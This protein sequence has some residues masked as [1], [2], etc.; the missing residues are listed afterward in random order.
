[1]SLGL[2]SSV[3]RD[4][5]RVSV[6]L[7]AFALLMLPAIEQESTGVR[8][9]EARA[10]VALV[11]PSLPPESAYPDVVLERDP[12]EAVAA[13]DPAFRTGGPNEAVVRAVIGGTRPLA[14][15]EFGGIV[16]AVSIGDSIGH[17]HVASIGEHGVVLDSGTLLTFADAKS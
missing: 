5:Q 9:A 16:R 12:F 4:L 13:F 3:R 8:A 17:E 1:V 6:A 7:C 2:S 10:A 14:L 15:I 11:V